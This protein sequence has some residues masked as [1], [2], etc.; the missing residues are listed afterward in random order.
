MSVVI[1][2][3]NECMIRRYE[4]LCRSYRCKAK[5]YIQIEK[6]MRNIGTPDLLVLFT[7]TMSH[8]MLELASGQAKKRNIPIVRSQTGSMSA[9]RSILDTHAGAQSRV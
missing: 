9:L 2:G 3:G 1:L 7:G 4:E 8:K 5:V 6:G